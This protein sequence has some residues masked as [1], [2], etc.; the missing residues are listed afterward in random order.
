[1]ANTVIGFFKNRSEAE[2]AVAQLTSSGINR[3]DIDISN[4]IDYD[5]D[6]SGIQGSRSD[7]S[8]STSGYTGSTSG[9]TGSTSGYT[10]STSGYT[11]STSG[12]TGNASGYTGNASGYTRNNDDVSDRKDYDDDTYRERHEQKGNAVSRFF[13]SL[14]G[15]DSDDSRKYTSMSEKA[16][17]IVTVHTSSGTQA[18][19]AANILDSCGAMDIDEGSMVNDTYAEANAYGRSSDMSDR[20]DTSTTSR[21]RRDDLNN[22]E[23]RIDVMREDLQVGKRS[24]ET[25][26]VRIRSRIIEKPVE[27]SLR[28]R[29][30]H[31]RIHRQPVDKAANIN[32]MDSFREKEIELTEYAE[33]PVVNKEARVV[34]EIRVTKE[35]EERE[36][37]VRETLRETKV[38]IEDDAKRS[39]RR[40]LT[41]TDT[42]YSNDD[43]NRRD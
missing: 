42:N 3:E 43:L 37:T 36:E 26:G 7:L 14:F 19:E 32:D 9:Y 40:D 22:E 35:V 18:E 34:E 23:E 5:S 41:G 16:D 31:V 10:G 15:D 8:G 29:E 11:G 13:N 28:L 2:D 1:M 4:S 21:D 39:G 6:S 17:T 33:V 20:S 24:V 27:E 38:E 12:Y 25:G 30:E